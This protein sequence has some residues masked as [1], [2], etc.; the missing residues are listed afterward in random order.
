MG[1]AFKLP[2]ANERRIRYGMGM[3]ELAMPE[4]DC[5]IFF[6]F[7]GV[8]VEIAPRPQD[9][10]VA[11][12]V[13]PLLSQLSLALSGA[14]AIVS[15]RPVAEIDHCLQP[16]KLPAAGVHGAERRGADGHLRRVVLGGELREAQSLIEAA[17]RR[18]PA[19]HFEVKPGAIALHYRQAPKLH[20]ECLAIMNEAMERAQDMMV[21]R[22]KMVFEL[23]PKHAGKDM[24]V[25]AFLEE[26]PFRSRRPWFFGDDVTDEAA[27]EAVQALGG[28]AV[29][30][31]EGETMARHRLQ[32]PAT[33][34][35][36]MAAAVAH[37]TPGTASRA[38]S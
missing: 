20:D 38:A 1:S 19:L 31:G 3:P 10:R 2:L 23:K 7:D 14:L 13:L 32:D 30:I 9:V 12:G 25:R 33:L 26:Q 21:L 17:C 8:L 27:F 36:W 18:H 34:Q 35:R 22:G 11:P 29:K 6:D 16:L 28:V 15:G 5:A 37:I 4:R 24:A